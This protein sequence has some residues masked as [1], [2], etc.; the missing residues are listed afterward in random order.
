MKHIAR[1]LFMSA[2]MTCVVALTL[3]LNE[4]GWWIAKNVSELY[5]ILA[6]IIL[7]SV[8]YTIIGAFQKD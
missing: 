1:F 8:M 4:L 6:L 3:C 7:S 5:W 2:I